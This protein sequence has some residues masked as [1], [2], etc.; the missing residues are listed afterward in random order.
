M[1]IKKEHIIITVITS[2]ILSISLATA[3][4]QSETPNVRQQAKLF[5]TGQQGMSINAEAV[6]NSVNLYKNLSEDKKIVIKEKMAQRSRQRQKNIEAVEK[7]IKELR[8]QG[9]LQKSKSQEEQVNRLQEIQQLALRENATE[10]VKSLA[11]LI[12]MYENNSQ[13]N[14]DIEI[15]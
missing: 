1:N 12:N 9:K 13:N 6:K 4:M 3:G 14:N 10:T 11:S 15:R 2:I 8:I 7:Q 5:V